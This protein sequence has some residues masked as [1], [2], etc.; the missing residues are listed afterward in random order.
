MATVSHLQRSRVA[1]RAVV[2]V[3]GSAGVPSGVAEPSKGLGEAWA[4]GVPACGVVAQGRRPVLSPSL[5]LSTVL[6]SADVGDHDT[7]VTVEKRIPLDA[8]P[9]HR[10]TT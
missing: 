3:G 6:T 5:A 10:R 4:T 8:G 7:L 1:G 2:S 9:A